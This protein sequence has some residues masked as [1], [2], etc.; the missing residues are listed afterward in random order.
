M[1]PAK[2]YQ[3]LYYSQFFYVTNTSTGVNAINIA[4]DNPGDPLISSSSSN[5]NTYKTFG[6]FYTNW[7]TLAAKIEYELSNESSVGVNVQ[8]LLTKT[9][10]PTSI[11]QA[12]YQ[13]RLAP[14]TA[15]I[16]A[17]IS[18]RGVFRRRFYVKP[19]YLYSTKTN[20]LVDDKDFYV[21]PNFLTT[22]ATNTTTFAMEIQTADGSINQK[23]AC[24]VRVVYYGFY[25]LLNDTIPENMPQTPVFT[26]PGI[27]K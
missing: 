4:V 15:L 10:N 21:E 11:V 5:A 12:E 7:V 1:F 22:R 8:W 14:K 26:F 13:S 27:K 9:A 6:A 24:N 16:P 3:K 17:N 25:K 20:F 2:L 18:E 19:G 23:I